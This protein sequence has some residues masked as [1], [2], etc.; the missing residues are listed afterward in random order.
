MTKLLTGAQMKA[1]EAAAIAS[2][3]VTGTDLMER[4]GKGVVDAILAEWP[5]AAR[6]THRAVVLCGPGGN[7]GDGFVI[8]R[9]LLARGWLVKVWFLGQRDCQPPDAA[10]AHDR[11]IAAGGAVFAIPQ[12]FLPDAK[13]PGE[14]FSQD[15]FGGHA[16]VIDAL[17][18]HGLTRPIAEDSGLWQA[19]AGH[20]DEAVREEDVCVHHVA[21]DVPSGL[22]ADSGRIISPAGRAN[23]RPHFQA[24]LTVATGSLKLGHFLDE[25]PECCGKV[26]LAEI[27]PLGGLGIGKPGCRDPAEGAARLVT[28]KRA[29]FAGMIPGY[30][31]SRSL[32]KAPRFAGS[33]H[34]YD[35]GHALVLSGGSGRGG[36]ARLAARGA[37]RI[38]SLIR[39]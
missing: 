4:A 28:E 8:A 16:F 37:L 6:G 20:F 35:H 12:P 31:S 29:F 36:A 23:F 27:G 13:R 2:G 30:S 21:V 1:V 14:M 22:C 34:K 10:K 18:G 25:G 9:L 7:G 39:I 15:V 32:A 26:V 38:L 33:A 17:F 24:A 5:E 19:F 11:W 3:F